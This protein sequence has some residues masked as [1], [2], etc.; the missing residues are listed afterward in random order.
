MTISL[1]SIATRRATAHDV[2]RMAAVLADA[3][4]GDPT[5]VHFFPRAADRRKRV[6]R[7]FRLIALERMALPHDA[8]YVTTGEV[9]GAAL[10]LPSSAA[11]MSVLDQLRMLPRSLRVA[12]LDLPRHIRGGAAFEAAHPH[13]PHWYLL[14][15]GVAPAAQGRGI[16]SALM[17]PMLDVCDGDRIGAYLDA[18]TERNRK[19]YERH[20]FEVIGEF[21]LP[22]GGP[23]LWRMWRQPS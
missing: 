11:Q 6:E 13:E 16:G 1:P 23:R 14:F 5:F 22:D 12:G 18:T 8:T 4:A 20:G 10:W 2:P 17:R 9:A 15:A 3:F 21:S 19:L 7:F